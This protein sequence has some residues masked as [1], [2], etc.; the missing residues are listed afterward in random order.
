MSRA[1]MVQHTNRLIDE[2]SPY[3][4]Q[5]AHNPVDWF[6]WGEEALEKARREDKPIL[7][8]IGYSSC[9]WCHVME[10]ESFENEEVAEYL[11][12]YFVSI[13]VDREERPDLDDVY[14]TAVQLMTGSGGWPMTVFLMPNLKP[15]FGGTYFPPEDMEGRPGFPTV[16]RSVMAAWVDRRNE[17]DQSADEIAA[18]V[19]QHLSVEPRQGVPVEATL[20]DRAASDLRAAHDPWEG[21]F[22]G[23]PKFPPVFAIGFL[24]RHYVNTRDANLL[25]MAMLTLDK[26]ARGGIYDQIGGGFHRYS[27]DTQWL[28]PHFEK[29]LY[30]NAQLASVYLEAFQLTR[31]PLYERIARETLEYLL[32][33][34][35]TEEGAFCSAEDADSDGGEGLFYLWTS[36]QVIAAL[37]AEKARIFN[38][39]FNVRENGNFL[40]PESAHAG[41]NILHLAR[42]PG[43]IARQFDMPRAEF[44]ALINECRA[45][46]LKVR[47]LRPRPFRD[48]KI[49]ASWNGLAISALARASQVLQESKWLH[50]AERAAGF[51][52][53][54]MLAPGGNL[55]RMY[56]DNEARQPA[57]L[58][59]YVLLAAGLLDLY[60]TSFDPSR[61]EQAELLVR[62]LLRDFR[63]P[64]AP[65]FFLAPVAHTDL[66]AQPKP[67]IDGAEPAGNAVAAHVLQRLGRLRDN[68]EYLELARAIIEKQALSIARMPRGFLSML[69]TAQSMAAPPQEIVLIGPPDDDETRALREALHERFHPFTIMAGYGGTAPG[70]IEELLPLLKGKGLVNGRAAAYICRNFACQAPVIDPEGLRRALDLAEGQM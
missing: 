3:L 21:G 54:N 62:T 67:V 47:S 59:D 10:V 51:I 32:R 19:R 4:L 36:G 25:D 34:M 1:G 40:S 70:N 45:A 61:V 7:L 63:D 17:L 37:G 5:H 68:R 38:A 9:H 57:F 24:L 28:T 53:D 16:L 12:E 69:M 11:N 60:E 35:T 44:D 8:S 6:P 30:D 14:M 29:M 18:V 23:A 41:R 39:C 22:G 2:K 15:F 48:D 31:N 26:M 65:G 20:F 13:K 64:S 66:I 33:D 56:R 42:D 52:L 58:D 55:L 46:L 49:L 27:T 50:A 43:E